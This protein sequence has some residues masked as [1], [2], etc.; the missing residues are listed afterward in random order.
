MTETW[1]S[2]CLFPGQPW[3]PFIERC[4]MCLGLAGALR[5]EGDLH[6]RAAH[7]LQ[8]ACVTVK[9]HASILGNVR[10]QNC[11]NENEVGQCHLVCSVK[12]ATKVKPLPLQEGMALV[13]QMI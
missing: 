8:R 1:F 10:F 13:E 7:A 4:Q 11:H 2:S 3:A 12:F 9:G 6:F 5:I